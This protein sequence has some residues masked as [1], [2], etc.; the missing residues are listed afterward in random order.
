MLKS[1]VII[2]LV[3][4][5]I[6]SGIHYFGGDT[7]SV[8]DQKWI[9]VECIAMASIA[10]VLVWLS[11]KFRQTE[12]PY[13]RTQ[14]LYINTLLKFLTAALVI[15]AFVLINRP[16]YQRST[17]YLMLGIYLVYH[18]ITTVLLLRSSE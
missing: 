14:S 1:I 6:F 11:A 18:I 10:M 2:S 7:I 12:D 4:L 16:D 13:L 17:V 9:L 3:T 15:G 5:L 8:R